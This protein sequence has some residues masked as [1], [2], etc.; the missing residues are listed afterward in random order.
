MCLQIIFFTKGLNSAEFDSELCDLTADF[1]FLFSAFCNFL[2]KIF[3]ELIAESIS[4]CC[5]LHRISNSASLLHFLYS[6]LAAGKS[7]HSGICSWYLCGFQLPICSDL[8]A[9]RADKPS[10][11]IS[12]QES[13]LLYYMEVCHHWVESEHWAN[14]CVSLHTFHVPHLYSKSS[15]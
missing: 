1:L 11:G 9:A 14:V 2:F 15:L 6:T 12:A 8:F 4:S 13:H 5:F 7:S 3:E 10:V